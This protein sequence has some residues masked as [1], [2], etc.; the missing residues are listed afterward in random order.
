MHWCTAISWPLPGAAADGPELDA[1]LFGVVSHLRTLE[2]LHL[3][4]GW[5]PDDCTPNA[6]RPHAAC[7]SRL[8]S[9][10]GLTRL[11]LKLSVCY[12]HDGDSYRR[13]EDDGEQHGAWV[14]VWEAHRT[15]LLSALRCMP[16]LQHL[17]CPTLWLRPSE[18]P[19]SLTALTSLTL[20][21]LL[22][23][24]LP[25]AGQ[26]PLGLAAAPVASTAL[27]PQ[28][29]E[30][31]LK[32]GTSPRAL[33]QLQPPPSL[34]HLDVRLVRFGVSDVDEDRLRA[35]AVAAVGPAVR[36]LLAYRRRPCGP[37][38]I[39]IHGDGGDDHLFPRGGS[40]NGHMEWIQ[41]LQGLD[42]FKK[43]ELVN[44]RL[45]PADLCCLGQALPDLQGKAQR[46][47]CQPLDTPLACSS[48]MPA[49]PQNPQ[50]CGKCLVLPCLL[51]GEESKSPSARCLRSLLHANGCT[52]TRACVL[53][54]KRK[55]LWPL[56]L[57]ACCLFA[58][59]PRPPTGCVC[60]R[61][62][63]WTPGLA[64][65]ATVGHMSASHPLCMPAR[66]P[67]PARLLVPAGRPARPAAPHDEPRTPGGGP[68]LPQQHRPRRADVS[69]TAAGPPAP[70]GN[71]ASAPEVLALSAGFG[72]RLV[73][74]VRHAA[75][76]R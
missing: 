27:P 24:P 11:E 16:Q 71:A 8:S 38:M 13:Q 22:P 35:E 70:R 39:C 47:R 61:L 6:V 2:T 19:A 51:A 56:H 46:N 45:H 25:P 30:L 3:A 31:V 4:L 29:Q 37:G 55:L 43:L 63:A 9:L 32:E 74:A 7:A 36:T 41:Q 33:A 23:P 59:T 20:G 34:V 49:W 52:C 15:S 12:E 17:D 50:P 54:G 48:G 60:R 72:R 64:H 57:P 1:R 40:P 42:V 28:L 73:R 58:V 21:G 67:G 14:E 62:H 75:T 18:L 65:G 10:T 5:Y 53:P 76:G 26:E 68:R 44:V 69:R 66:R